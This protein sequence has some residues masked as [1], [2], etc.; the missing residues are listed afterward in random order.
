MKQRELGKTEFEVSEIGHGLWGM[1]GWSDAD[2]EVS[3]AALRLSIEGG[4]TFFDSAYVYGN[5]RSDGR[6]CPSAPTLTPTIVAS[7]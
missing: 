6:F 3:R 4:C 7:T 5:G 2:D 1:G